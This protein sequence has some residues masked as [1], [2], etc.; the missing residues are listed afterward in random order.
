MPV[1]G[2]R[3]ALARLLAGEGGLPRT[4]ARMWG[5]LLPAGKASSSPFF[6]FLRF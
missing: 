2:G 6:F 5:I 4:V 1:D 3:V